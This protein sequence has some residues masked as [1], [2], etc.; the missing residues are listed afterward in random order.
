MRIEVKALRIRERD[1]S[2]SQVFAVK[3]CRDCYGRGVIGRDAESGKHVLCACVR[4][5]P[6]VVEDQAPAGEPLA[7]PA[8]VDE[9]CGA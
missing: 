2:L 7:Q 9:V 1:E 3:N 8:A 5:E 6:A 4:I